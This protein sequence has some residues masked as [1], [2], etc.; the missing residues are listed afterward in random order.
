M[1]PVRRVAAFLFD[2]IVGDDPLMFSVVCV[3]LAA[4]G[5]VAALGVASWWL[6]PMSVLVALAV[7]VLRVR[8][9]AE[10]AE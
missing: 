2:F 5:I 10:T 8:S 4:T 3:G 1:N 7:S 6:L 9:R